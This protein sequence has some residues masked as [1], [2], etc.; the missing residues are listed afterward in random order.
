MTFLLRTGM[1]PMLP[2]VNG[3]SDR[4][5][6]LASGAMVFTLILLLAGTPALALNDAQQ[7]VVESWRLVN[8]GYLDPVSYTHLTLPTT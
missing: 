8:Q 6:R 4:L 1:K 3:W 7:L 2:T 5:R